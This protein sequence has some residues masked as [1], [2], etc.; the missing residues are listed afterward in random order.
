MLHPP[1]LPL[2]AIDRA[3][4]PRRQPWLKPPPATTTPPPR[5]PRP[6]PTRSRSVQNR[7]RVRLLI[8][9]GLIRRDDPWPGRKRPSV[10]R[11]AGNKPPRTLGNS[12]V[13]AYSWPCV[14]VFVEVW[15]EE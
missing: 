11:Q 3:S 13:R 9:H 6:D 7:R 5:P 14:L 12:E 1:R 4:A 2:P 15:R 8:N 10:A